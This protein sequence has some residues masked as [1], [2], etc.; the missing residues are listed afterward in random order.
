M[1]G[2][3]ALGRYVKGANLVKKL[4]SLLVILFFLSTLFN[5]A[6]AAPG[7]AP[8]PESAWPGPDGFG[9]LGLTVPYEWVELGGAGTRI[10]IAGDDQSSAALDF[11]F[12]FPFYGTYYSQFY[13]QTNGTIALGTAT[14]AYENHCPLPGSDLA[15]N[16]IAVVWDD[17]FMDDEA[18]ARYQTFSTCPV[19]SGEPCLVVEWANMDLLNGQTAGTWEALL[20]SSGAIRLQFQDVG[21]AAGTGSTTGIEGKNAGAYYG[22]TYNCDTARSIAPKLAVQLFLPE[23]GLYLDPDLLSFR[24]CNGLS[25]AQTVSLFNHTGASGLFDLTY[26]LTSGDGTLEGPGSISVADD[27]VATFSVVLASDVCSLS[28]SHVA[29]TITAAGNGYGDQ[30][31]VDQVV[32]GP[33][34]G[35]WQE[36]AA[37]PV[38]TR[39]HAAAYLDGYLYQIGGDTNR[40]A[41][42]NSVRRL[43][44]ASGEWETRNYLPAPQYGMDAVSS[45][46][47]LYLAGGSD[48]RTDPNDPGPHTF[49]NTLWVYSPSENKWSAA[50]PLPAARAF[51]SA[52]GYGKKLYVLGGEADNGVYQRSLFIYDMDKAGWS[53]GTPMNEARGY[54]AAAVVDGKIYVAGGYAGADTVLQTMEIYDIATNRWTDGPALP[55]P[56]AP[57]GDGVL[58]RSMIVYGG[59]TVEWN[60]AQH[61]T[62]NCSTDAYA[63]DTRA[64]AWL[65]LPALNR[66]LY[67][68]AGGGDANSSLYL[69]SGRTDTD[70]WQAARQVDRLDACPLCDRLGWL[71]GRVLDQ[72][73][74]AGPICTA[75][76]VR[77][78]P[79]GLSVPVDPATGAYGPLALVAGTYTVTASAPGF[80]GAG[81]SVT[82]VDDLTVTRDLAL[83]RPVLAG[84]PAS[85]YVTA[86][87]TVPVTLSL[88]LGNEGHR[89][90]QWQLRE[91]P[92][93][94]G[95]DGADRQRPA[96]VG[97]DP[98]LAEQF[99]AA[100]EQALDFFISFRDTADLY[101]ARA[102][103]S[104]AERVALVRGALRAAADGAQ[105]DVRDWLKGQ[106]VPYQV[107]YIDNT[108]LVRGSRS[109]VEK[110]SAFPE[111]S[112]FYGNHI[113]QV[114]PDSM[115]SAPAPAALV[116]WDI[117]IMQLDRAW[118]EL[119]V[120]GLGVVVANV[121]TGVVYRHPALFP[122]YLCGNGPHADCWFDPQN[123]TTAPVDG[124]GHGTATMSQIAAD[125][126]PTLPY[127]VGGAPDAG[128]IACLGCP[129]GSCPATVLNACAEWLVMTTTNT[130]D[131]VN[132]SWGSS[133]AG[134]DDWYQ[135]KLQAYRA[136][137]ILPIFSAGNA[138]NSC[139]TSRSPANN[140][141]AL[142]VGATG[143][144][145]LQAAFSS[146]GPGACSGRTQFPD[147]AAPGDLTCGATLAGG[148]SCG[149]SGTSF[150]APRAAGCAA[151]VKSANPNLTADQV[152]AV[153]EA[154]A[155]DRPDS[156]C[157]SPQPD[158]NYRYGEGRL[159][160]YEAVRSVLQADVS[161]LEE[162]PITGTTAPFSTT[163][164]SVTFHCPAGLPGSYAGT[165]SVQS[166]DPCTRRVDLPVHLE[167]T[168]AC[169]PVTLTV[170]AWTPPAPAAGAPVTFHA[171]VGPPTAGMPF[172]FTWSF[173]D[174][175]V[176]QGPTFSR[177]F[178][179]T[180]SY[181][182]TLTVANP[183]GVATAVAVVPVRAAPDVKLVYLPLVVR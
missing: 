101:V 65:R 95:L 5:P 66:C 73:G 99:D 7:P 61:T 96:A 122:N 103:R 77:I 165:L 168:A 19:G 173:T 76:A 89:P 38:G 161:W 123:G 43:E 134:C 129:G 175:T 32:E 13:A 80:V 171:T 50:A 30:A 152:Q 40:W 87:A 18:W 69:V 47:K 111:V 74:G 119:G 90:L 58:G 20:Y 15:D 160:C 85:L 72:E 118:N 169:V 154:T 179:L 143:A 16:V 46:G 12:A 59:G 27:H 109:L 84:L 180:G 178:A 48:D 2:S 156:D 10:S 158:P 86:Y 97:I 60:D 81:Y 183:C 177:T 63:Y 157:A 64:G 45:G 49:L 108:I 9:Y 132:N 151:L 17:L 92:A 141:G 144:D 28:G 105:A 162:D 114:P 149:F 127:A 131:L 21:A 104:K 42:T 159:N 137:G 11:G 155:D 146:S 39:F 33:F 153:L 120:T 164:S 163:V 52:V 94:G 110:L 107:F 6:A 142:A 124:H 41:P 170:P 181:A 62:Y 172:S 14:T 182:V 91:F 166:D 145:D 25:R 79:L 23:P 125:N 54:A 31:V 147:V 176:V 133:A 24:D 83:D 93:P 121:D 71:D 37:T 167:C 128:W 102:G 116:P 51:A 55:K 70:G 67:G 57:Y 117:A 8:L 139:S 88:D 36:S 35:S 113:Y 130:P 56:W 98:F 29:G 135:G 3:L 140:P 106:G 174:G 22:L 112:G 4:W 34:S 115:V 138:G 26:A 126:D 53:M 136:A 82:V 68:S 78:E 148:Y 44:L 100:P 150:A 1:S 75:P